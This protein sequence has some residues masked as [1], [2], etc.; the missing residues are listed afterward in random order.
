MLTELR[1]FIA[2]CRHGTF[3]AAGDR[4]GLTQSAVSS[5]IKRLED[6]LGFPLFQRTGRAAVLNAAGHATLPRA[7][8][9]SA[10]CAK[11]IDL[12]DE[13][14]TVGM[15]RLGAIASAQTTLLPRALVMLRQRF[16]LLRIHVI[17][18]LS[19][20]LTD[21]LDSGQIDAA[22]IIKPPF[23]ILHDMTWQPLVREPYVLVV[24]SDVPGEDWRQLVQQNPLLRYERT[25]FGGRMV[26]RFIQR[27]SLSVHDAIELDEIAGLV[28]LVAVG[29]GVA[30]VPLAEANLPLPLGVRMISLGEQTF[31]REIGVM[32]RRVS[33]APAS[34]ILLECLLESA[35]RFAGARAVDR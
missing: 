23:G 34:N 4:I 11:L 12:P 3:Q 16:P 33:E 14:M 2:V 35:A 10:L 7:E 5:Q 28:N 27:E 8:E 19:I 22:I 26:E 17:P 15:M 9:I 30:I 24:P 18:G 6:L 1:T 13:A 29:A 20:A 21:A 31:F 25:S 32:Q